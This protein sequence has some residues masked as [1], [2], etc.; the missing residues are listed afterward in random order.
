[1]P[2]LD[3]RVELAGPVVEHRI[4]LGELVAL[5][6]LRDHMKKLRPLERPDVLQRRNEGVQIMAVNRPEVI[7]SELLEQR[8][9]SHHALGMLLDLLRQL[10]QRR[11]PAKHLL[12]GLFRY[13]VEIPGQQPREI[14]VECADGRRDR[15]VVVVEYHQQVGIH[16]AGVVQRLKGHAGRHRAVADHGDAVTFFALQ[17]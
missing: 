9:G 14:P 1:L 6:L 3:L 5:A 11:H 12:T 16:H 17:L 8:G 15:H 13:R 10:P 2:P 7:E 4:G